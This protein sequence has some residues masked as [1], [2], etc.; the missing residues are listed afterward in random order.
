VL[1]RH[2]QCELFGEAKAV[3]I[4]VK[5]K[6]EMLYAINTILRTNY[7]SRTQLSPAEMMTVILAFRLGL[8]K[9]GGLA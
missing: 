8:W 7:T 5:N 4:D 1:H 6:A 2:I 9:K 3:G